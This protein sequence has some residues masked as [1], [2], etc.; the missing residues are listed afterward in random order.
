MKNTISI[1]I[2]ILFFSCTAKKTIMQSGFDQKQKQ[3]NA[4]SSTTTDQTREVTSIDDKQADSVQTVTKTIKYDTTKP[5]SEVTG[6]A[7]VVEETTITEVKIGNKTINKKTEVANNIQSNKTDNSKIE[8][9]LKEQIKVV[10]IPKPPA[11][12]YYFYILIT[13]ILLAAGYFVYRNIAKIR[14][15]LGLL[16]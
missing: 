1:L 10:E 7:P 2:F 12:K 11:A 9:E 13:L 15:F 14:G 4:I 5:V 3:Q 16:S 8:T 6:K